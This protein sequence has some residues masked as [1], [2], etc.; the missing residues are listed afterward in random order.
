M[1]S[2]E[3]FRTADNMLNEG[4]I[5]SGAIT[6]YGV[7]SRKHADEAVRAF[8]SGQ[9]ALRQ[10]SHEQT[11]EKRLGGIEKS[12]DALFDGLIK[13]RLQIGAGVAVNIAGHTLATKAKKTR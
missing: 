8:R 12:L 11:V 6:S 2:F 5:R 3:E 10:G 13:M 4:I 1:K 9:E 7:Q